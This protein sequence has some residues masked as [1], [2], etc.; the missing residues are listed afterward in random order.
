LQTRPIVCTNFYWLQWIDRSI[1]SK[2]KGFEAAGGAGDATLRLVITHAG[3]S[4]DGPTAETFSPEDCATSH[5]NDRP[6]CLECGIDIYAIKPT[7]IKLKQKK[8]N[9]S[10]VTNNL[11]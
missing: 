3:S 11:P 2:M 6:P 4:A 1:G 7:L 10:S 8:E 9:N 5:T